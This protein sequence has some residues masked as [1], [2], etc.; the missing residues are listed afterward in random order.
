M[1]SAVHTLQKAIAEGKQPVTQLLRE[2]KLIAAKLGLEDMGKWVD[3]ELNG[4]SSELEPPPY[5]E[6]T[7][8]AV[9][10]CHPA[11]GWEFAGHFHM[12]M[13][14]RQPIAEIEELSGSERLTLAL[15]KNLPVSDGI[16]GSFGA[17]WPQRAIISGSSFRH[18]VEAVRN[19]L[20]EWSIELEKRGIKGEN[21]DFDESEK[22]SATNQVFNIQQFTGV[23]GNVNNSH[24]TLYDYSSIQQLLIDRKVPKQDR[25]ELEDILDELKQAT[26]E[27]RPSLLARA[28]KWLGEHKEIMGFG[29]D[30]VAKA[31]GVM[32]NQP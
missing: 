1:S 18:I 13:K 22:K 14:A 25:R 16:G 21:M 31:A 27:K 8:Q 2:T 17:R 5:R 12:K 10:I 9:E 20:L 24:V 26:P 23:L 11:R 30:A 32:M 15:T 19:A 3:G 4:Y 29:I 6:F 28:E 7:T